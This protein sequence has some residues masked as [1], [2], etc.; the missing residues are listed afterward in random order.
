MVWP[1]QSSVQWECTDV[2]VGEPQ[3]PNPENRVGARSAMND[4]AKGI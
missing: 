1:N 2:G 3:L 4:P